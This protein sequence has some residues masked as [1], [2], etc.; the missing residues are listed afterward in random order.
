MANTLDLDE[1]LGD[2]ELIESLEATFD[3]TFARDEFLHAYTV[4]EMF[5]HLL[6]RIDTAGAGEKCAS[7]MAFYRLRRALSAIAPDTAMT[8]RTELTGLAGLTVKKLF[9]R[10]GQATGLKTPSPVLTPL[11]TIG[12]IAIFGAFLAA[13]V[14]AAAAPRWIP[15]TIAAGLLGWIVMKIDGGQLG[16]DYVTLGGLAKTMATLNYGRLIK[17]GAR[18]DVSTLWQVFLDVVTEHS[19]LPRREIARDTR[20]FRRDRKAA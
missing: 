17:D 10:L 12:L 14:L 4:G 6:T 3:L 11:G 18:G 8:P 1:E 2:V 15:A 20:F 19:P 5:D 16:R 9:I 7:A 13:C